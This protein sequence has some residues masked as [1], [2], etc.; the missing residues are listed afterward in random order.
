MQR[1]LPLIKRV[2]LLLCMSLCCAVGSASAQTKF[3]GKVI[4]SDD[5][6]PI[7]GAS[8]KIKNSPGGTTTDANGAFAL[9]VKP[10][11]VLIVSFVGYGTKEVPVGRQSNVTI[12]LLADNNNLTEVV[13]TGYTSQRKKDL[14]GAVSVV[15]MGLLK[16]QPAASAVEALQGKATGVQIIND[17]A[18]GA[19]PQIRIRGVSTINNNEPLYVIDGVPF[20]GKLSWLNQNDI[21][22]LQVLK[23][24]SSASIYGSRANNGV[25]IITT[26]KGVA[27]TPKITF[28]TYFGIQAPRKSSFPKMMNPQQYADYLF[29]GYK[30]AGLTPLTGTNYGNGATPT[31]PDYLVAGPK[32]GQ[33][34]TPADADPSKYNYS[35]DPATFYQITKANKQGTN[36]F[37]E[38]TDSAPIQ[39][40]QLSATGGGENATYTF[41]GGYLDQ[42]G[43]IRYTG[44]KRYNFRTN[45]NISAFNKR[46]RFG[47]NA[48][49]SYSEGYGLGVN[50]NVSGDYQ[51][52]GSAIGWAYRIPTIIPVYDIMG[53]FAG[54]RGSNLGNAENPLAFLYRA[55]DNKNKSNFFFG[56]V[57]AEGDIIPGLVLRTNFGLRYE[58]FN[59]LSM[60]YPNLEFSEGN[61]SNNLN[62]YQGY[63]TEWTWTNTLNYS[64]VINEKH[65]L[66]VLVGTEAIRSRTRQL[67]GGRNDFFLLGNQDYYYLNT[68]SSNISNSSY[69]S[70]GS[71]FSLFGKI[72]YSYHDRYLAS[73]T[74]RRDGSSNFGPAN[75]YGFYPAA[76]AAWRISEED[77]MK[78]IKWVT[79]LKLRVG[80]G[81]TG[82]QRIPGNQYL[83][84]FQ[85]SI[86]SAAYAVGGGNNLTTGVWQ[87]QY[88]NPNIKWES[89]S[90]LNI[91]LDFT[92]LSGAFDGSLD[93]YNRK[94]TDMLY[95]VPLPSTAVG[96]GSSP[97][98]N[99]GDMSNKGVEFSLAYH[100]GRKE[101]SPFKFDVGV[102]FS[103]NVNKIVKLAPGIDKQPYGNY[104]SLQTSIMEE[105]Q[106][107][108]AFY[109]YKVA[110]IYQNAA[111]LAKYPSYTGARVGGFRYADVNGDGK[112]DPSDRTII[113]NPNPDFMYSLSLNASYKNFD[114]AAFFNGVQGNDLYEA[115]RYFT[116]F[117][118]F[119]GARSTRLLNAW[120]P[121]NPTSM[122]PSSYVGVSDLEYAS[123]SYYVQ[124]GS[125]FRMKNIQIGYSFPTTKMFGPKSGINK[126]RVYVSATNLFTITKYTG[127]DPEVSQTRDASAAVGNAGP[128]ADT[129]SALGVDKGVYPSPRQ[130]LIGINVGF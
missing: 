30:N 51:D 40:Y 59:G 95:P 120:S 114:I 108:G 54:S 100:Y 79:D 94:T 118:T 126:L 4:A 122:I 18:P 45:T 63:N 76:S 90:S 116:D 97:Y 44:F 121:T 83:N 21:E 25:V 56:N 85:S 11:D 110:G 3:I 43:T 81:R 29:A 117:P 48:Q 41:S 58:N 38:I 119:D 52:Q 106:P 61:N 127:L 26:K 42:K 74:M 62:E 7:I 31:L 77:F 84:I 28:D 93:W 104:R 6:M 33:D 20:E 70:I 124:K 113:G 27:G 78:S 105:G 39:N 32:T 23:D 102:N 12:V 15:N 86:S 89:L 68:G 17:G 47:E 109:G 35:R 1:N 9:Q 87:N 128:P 57:F 55:K 8:I 65:R 49:Y 112:I 99:V 129:F 64:K 115:T 82:N 10:T 37:D 19:T 107:F 72:D 73:I 71:L 67:N 50:P 80:Y 130:F 111:D 103:K 2:I 16:S 91:G 75:K 96:L 5:K 14:T 98:Q 60:R 123:S 53:N 13:V 46:V 34:V 101:D 125:Y 69:G 92:L 22:S 88:Q 24:A 66:N 36:W